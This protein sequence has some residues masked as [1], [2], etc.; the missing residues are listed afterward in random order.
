MEENLNIFDF[1]LTVQDMEAI[2][3]LNTEK[4]PIYDENDLATVRGIGTY[5][6]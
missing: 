3:A 5:A 2:A 6:F 1:T 4:S